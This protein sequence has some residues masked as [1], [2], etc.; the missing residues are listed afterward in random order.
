MDF[1]RKLGHCVEPPGVD[2]MPFLSS[3]S[4]GAEMGAPLGPRQSQRLLKLLLL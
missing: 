1:S 3:P 4:P 2:K